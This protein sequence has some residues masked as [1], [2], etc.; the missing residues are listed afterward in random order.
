MQLSRK[1]ENWTEKIGKKT[2]GVQAAKH[3][4]ITGTTCLGQTPVPF[5]E[6]RHCFN[7]DKPQVP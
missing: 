7:P 5:P 2:E 6:G 4:Q 1:Q 3:N